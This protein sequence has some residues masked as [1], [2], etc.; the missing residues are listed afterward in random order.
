MIK[1]AKDNFGNYVIQSLYKYSDDE[2]K[3]VLTTRLKND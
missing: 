3:R 1:M 2:V